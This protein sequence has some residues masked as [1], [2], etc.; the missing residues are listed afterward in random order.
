MPSTI[1][2]WLV[3]LPTYTAFVLLGIG[4]GIGVAFGYLRQRARRAIPPTVFLSAALVVLATAY[5]GAR[6]YHVALNWE[7]YSTRL[8]TIAQFGAGGLGM[9][10]AFITGSLAL[11][12]YARARRLNVGKLADAAA[13]GLAVG[14]AIGWVGA[15]ARGANYGVPSDAPFALE[16]A[17]V[18][19]LVAPRFPLQHLY[20]ALFALLFVGLWLLAL[21]KPRAGTLFLV[22]V[23]VSAAGNFIL[24][25]Q[26][27]DETLYIGALRVDQVVDVILLVFAASIGYVQHKSPQAEPSVGSG[28]ALHRLL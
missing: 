3:E 12:V 1:D 10:G 2:L 7:Y 13:L 16:L 9:R 8:E 11:I 5:V 25:F 20:I 23:L 6:A 15:L 18:Y 4:A 26:R 17:D 14:Q 27:G 24:G 21:A 28:K 19:G 22:Y